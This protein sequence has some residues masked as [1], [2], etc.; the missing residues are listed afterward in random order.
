ME[1]SLGFFSDKSSLKK[2]YNPLSL[3]GL[4]LGI[5]VLLATF[6]FPDV[7]A[8]FWVQE[9]YHFLA[10]IALAL[11][12]HQHSYTSQFW[13]VLSVAILWELFEITFHYLQPFGWYMH[14]QVNDVVLDIA[15]ALVGARVVYFLLKKFN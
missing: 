10:G 12:L 3:A 9:M 2:H 15:L 11:F 6:L 4:F 13:V 5:V 8:I 14:W 7:V 1:K